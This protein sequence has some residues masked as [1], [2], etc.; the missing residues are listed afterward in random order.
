MGFKR[1]LNSRRLHALPRLRSYSFILP[2]LHLSGIARKMKKKE[3][4]RIKELFQAAKR[5]EAI[6]R[7]SDGDEDHPLSRWRDRREVHLVGYNHFFPYLTI[8][9]AYRVN[10]YED[11]MEPYM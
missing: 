3:R 8:N 10:N 2:L 9:I 6:S 1:V 11:I 5:R 4:D 7:E